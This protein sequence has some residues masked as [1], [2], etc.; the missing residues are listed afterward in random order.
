MPMGKHLAQETATN[1]RGT[2]QARFDDLREPGWVP[3]QEMGMQIHQCSIALSE[4][5]NHSIHQVMALPDKRWLD[6]QEV[7]VI[8]AKRRVV[9]VAQEDRADR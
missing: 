7:E 5:C 3:G 6:I 8:V 1:L 2:T 4:L 9:D